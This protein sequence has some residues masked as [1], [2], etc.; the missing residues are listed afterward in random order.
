MIEYIAESYY[1]F[2]EY[3]LNDFRIV[4]GFSLCMTTFLSPFIFLFYILHC[5]IKNK[6]EKKKGEPDE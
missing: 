3:A 5:Y 6:K 4:F 2:L 1:Q